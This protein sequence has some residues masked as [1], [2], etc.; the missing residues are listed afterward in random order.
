M[1]LEISLFLRSISPSDHANFFYPL[2]E[3]ASEERTIKRPEDEKRPQK[4]VAP[5]LK[6]EWICAHTTST[7]EHAWQS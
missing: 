3:I 2:Q 5:T 6:Q 4:Q 7:I 1:L